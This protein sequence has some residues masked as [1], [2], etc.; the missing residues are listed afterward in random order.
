MQNRYLSRYIPI[1]H[2]GL[3]WLFISIPL[4]AQSLLTIEAVIQQVLAHNFDIQVARNEQA[5]ATIDYHAGKATFL[6]VLNAGAGGHVHKYYPIAHHK[7]EKGASAHTD[8]TL[9]WTVFNGMKRIFTCRHL[10][11]QSQISQLGVQQQIEEK[12]AEAIIAYYSLA[13]AQQKRHVLA[14]CLSVAKEVLQLAKSKYEIGECSKLSYLNAQVQHNEAQHKLLAQ[15]EALTAAKLHLYRLLNKDELEE[16]AIVVEDMSAPARLCYE[17]LKR[18][19]ETANTRIQ[20]AHKRCEDAA[21]VIKMKQADLF[22]Q[23]NL[24]LGYGLESQRHGQCWEAMSGGFKCGIS[25]SLNL[26]HAFQHRAA[27]QRAGI[28]ADNAQLKL[29]AQTLQVTSELKKQF[30][31]YSQQLQRYE[32]AQQHVQVS[33]ENVTVSLAQYRLGLITLLALNQARQNEQETKLNA[34]Q[35]LYG[36]KVAEVALQK[37]AGTLLDEVY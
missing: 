28:E 2:S 7:S 33:Q 36:A 13:L 11:K 15:E 8:I 35:V 32:L 12:V 20:V 23:V 29:R 14:D 16:P 37:L 18:A 4:Q 6:P 3:V 26:F 21:L 27:I 22:P 19:F 9:T 17:V 30:I 31:H 25:I 1:L 34:L 10:G 24:S 5:I